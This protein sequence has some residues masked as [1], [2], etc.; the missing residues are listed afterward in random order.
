VRVEDGEQ[1]FDAA[2]DVRQE[3]GPVRRLVGEGVGRVDQVA[4]DPDRLDAAVPEQFLQQR[5]ESGLGLQP[6]GDPPADRIRIV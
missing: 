4:D 1:V 3:C 2:L 5:G 6:L